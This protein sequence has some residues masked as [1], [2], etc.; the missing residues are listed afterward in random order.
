MLFSQPSGAG[1]N[2][3][4][5]ET[6]GAAAVVVEGLSCI[7]PLLTQ[8]WLQCNSYFSIAIPHWQCH[9]LLSYYF[10]FE[11]VLQVDLLYF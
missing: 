9:S 4:V 2:S 10:E 3:A 1:S 5:S 7:M 8:V 11:S 6:E